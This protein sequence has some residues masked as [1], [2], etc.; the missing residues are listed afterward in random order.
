MSATASRSVLWALRPLPVTRSLQRIQH[1]QNQERRSFITLPGTEGTKLHETRILPYKHTS[2]Y[3]LIADIDSYSKFLPYCLD[4]K[5]TEWSAPDESGRRWPAK[6]DLTVGWGGYEE[7]FTSKLFCAPNHAVEALGGDAQATLCKREVEH[8]SS[9]FDTPTTANNM[10]KSLSTRWTIRPFHY[11][12]PSGVP[13]TDKTIHPARDQTEV[14]LTIDFQFANPVYAAL[15]KAVAP[16]VA[17]IMI[18]AF[19]KRA[20]TLLDGPGAAVFEKEGLAGDK[21]LGM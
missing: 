10:F 17:G 6:A 19:E 12:P 14:N 20:R 13:Q 1:L 9:S 21:K 8:H 15:S 18:E 7:T 5:V 11:K 16:K 4:S 2:L 3:A